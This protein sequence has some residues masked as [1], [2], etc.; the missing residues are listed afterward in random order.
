MQLSKKKKKDV[1]LCDSNL[2]GEWGAKR[3]GAFT[4]ELG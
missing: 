4:E 3:Q 1:Y 2:Q